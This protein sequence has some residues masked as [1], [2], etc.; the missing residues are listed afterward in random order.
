MHGWQSESTYR[1]KS[2]WSCAFLEWLQWLQGSSHPQLL[3]VVW[4]IAAA[5]INVVQLQLWLQ[6]GVMSV[7]YCNVVQCAVL[8]AVVQSSVLQCKVVQLQL[9]QCSVVQ[10]SV[11]NQCSVVHLQL[12]LQLQWWLQLQCSVIS[13]VECCVMQCNLVQ[14]YLQLSL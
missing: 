11:C 13:V 14:L 6:C 7:V 9:A 3:D 5:V 4:C 12:Q 2:F 1:P 8:C 10:L